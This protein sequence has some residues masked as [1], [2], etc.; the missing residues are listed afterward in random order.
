MRRVC[1]EAADPLLEETDKWIPREAFKFMQE[2]RRNYNGELTDSLIEKL[3]FELNRI[4]SRRE[5][6]RLARLRSQYAAEIQRLQRQIVSMPSH[7]EV[8]AKKTI[9]RLRADLK[10]AHSENRK[11]FA[12]RT[13]K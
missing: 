3:L 12:E 4:W 5:Q 9:S 13:S 11:A 2:F 1:D 10:S 7:K 6:S 8:E